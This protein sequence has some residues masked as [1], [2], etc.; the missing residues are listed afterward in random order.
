M[1]QRMQK[2]HAF[3]DVVLPWPCSIGQSAAIAAETGPGLG[4]AI[5]GSKAGTKDARNTST[6][7]N[8]ERIFVL[9]LRPVDSVLRFR[10]RQSR[11]GL[12]AL[13]TERSTA[14][15]CAI[16]APLHSPG[17]FRHKPPRR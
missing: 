4:A 14:P 2:Q 11:H 17:R 10:M 12:N 8:G 3:S 9:H 5:T 6:A 7:R 13:A 16:R 1:I 15:P